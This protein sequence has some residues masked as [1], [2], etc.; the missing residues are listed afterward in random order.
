M[1]PLRI[2]LMDYVVVCG[3]NADYCHVRIFD[4][5][6]VYQSTALLAIP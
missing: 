6:T 2:S 5:Y 1:Y 4:H 3:Q